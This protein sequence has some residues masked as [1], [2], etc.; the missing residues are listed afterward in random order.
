[1]Q[2]DKYALIISATITKGEKKDSE[3]KVAN[4]RTRNH[5]LVEQLKVENEKQQDIAPFRN[6]ASSLQKEVNQILL[7]LVGEMY[8]IKQI[9]ARLKEIELSSSEFRKR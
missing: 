4:I 1:M 7:R 5:L 2:S 8:M 3:D 9:E 6:Q